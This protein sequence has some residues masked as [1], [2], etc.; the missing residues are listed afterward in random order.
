MHSTENMSLKHRVDRLLAKYGYDHDSEANKALHLTCVPVI[1][2]SVIALLWS[3]PGP[4]GHSF[5]N[6]ATFSLIAA[7]IYFIW[8]SPIL[9][10]GFA[11][12]S[13]LCVTVLIIYWQFFSPTY[14]P[15]ALILF[16]IASIGQFLGHK[17][18]GKRLSFFQYVQF[19]LIGPTWLI[20]YFYQ[21]LGIRY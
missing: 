9:A 3:V 17:I 7:L 4:F 11:I 19:L 13:A 18:E 16:S 1:L 12:F 20:N 8:L 2:W 14:W 6:W 15:D 21:R 10:I 5:L